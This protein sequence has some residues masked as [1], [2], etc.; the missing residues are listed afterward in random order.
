MIGLQS[1]HTDMLVR[2]TITNNGDRMVA[3]VKV[4]SIIYVKKTQAYM[5]ASHTSQRQT[6]GQH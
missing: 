2:S 5:R 1:W 6:S 3:I 4:G